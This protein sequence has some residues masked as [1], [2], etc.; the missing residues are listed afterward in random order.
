MSFREILLQNFSNIIQKPDR[1]IFGVVMKRI[2]IWGLGC[3]AKKYL[4]DEYFSEQCEIIAFIDNKVKKSDFT[5]PTEV[6]VYTP[7]EFVRADLEY[8]Y[9]V[10]ANA[11][12]DEIKKQCSQL[13][14]DLSKIVFAINYEMNREVKTFN[15]KQS[16]HQI[17]DISLKLFYDINYQKYDAAIKTSF[18]PLQSD[19]FD[20]TSLVVNES[21]YSDIASWDYTRCRCF[22]LCAY[23]II[24]GD[25]SGDTAE[26]GVFQG[27]F[28]KLINATFPEK[29]L[30]LFDTFESYDPEEFSE[31]MG[32][33]RFD[34]LC[35]DYH[36]DTS[37]ELV[38]SKMKYPSN[39]V[40]RKGYF[41]KTAEGLEDVRFSFVSIDLN[42]EQSTYDSLVWFMPRLNNGGYVFIHDY[43]IY[44][45]IQT[46]INRYEH[47]YGRLIKVPISDYAG[48]LIIT[49]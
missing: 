19:P 29:K 28:A 18:N 7:E 14:M 15:E 22:E 43:N 49:K 3:L 4:S 42:L 8:D 36:S 27:Q 38:M 46:A 12:S 2:V 13:Q 5:L 41:P 11:Y 21:D 34:K 26:A 39:C 37:I 6:F 45:S 20:K 35:F 17:K 47:D 30:F 31:E 1:I 25:I 32:K 44:E 48:T 24:N 10:V 33:G 23:E 9:I 16:I 40:V